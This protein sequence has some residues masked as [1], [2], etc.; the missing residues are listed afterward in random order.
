MPTFLVS[1]PTGRQFEVDGAD[2]NEAISSLQSYLSGEAAP[3]QRTR[4]T[5]EMI[6]AYQQSLGAPALNQSSISDEDLKSKFAEYE[7]KPGF[8]ESLGS[9]AERSFSQAGVLKDQLLS[10]GAKG[11]GYDDY[12]KQKLDEAAAKQ[13]EIQQTNPAQ[14]ESYKDVNWSNLPAY[15]G[16]SIGEQAFN[17][18][19]MLGFGGVGGAIGKR[20]AT[21]AA[22]KAVAEMAA[23]RAAAGA[24]EAAVPAVERLVAREAAKGA[25][26]GGN[27]GMYLG[28]FGL[29]AGDIY[30]GIYD[31]TGEMAPGA[32]VIGASI[33]GFL[34]SIVPARFVKA[35]RET[36]TLRAEV[37]ARIAA[38]KGVAE[39]LL[40]AVK[41]GAM[42][43]LKGGALEPITEVGQEIVNKLAEDIVGESQEKWGSEDFD[44]FIN[45][46]AKSIAPG[47]LFGF[48]EGVGKQSNRRAIA[49]RLEQQ[50][51][52]RQF[53]ADQLASEE[54]RKQQLYEG[55]PELEQQV[56]MLT[57]ALNLP[58]N[59]ARAGELNFNLR[60]T[61]QQLNDLSQ[62]LTILEMPRNQRAQFYAQQQQ[63]EEIAPE[64][65]EAPPTA[66]APVTARSV[67]EPL[68]V[69][70][71]DIKGLNVNPN[72][73]LRGNAAQRVADF[74]DQWR[75][76]PNLSLEQA[77]AADA[78]LAELPELQSDA[79]SVG[80]REDRE[81]H[82]AAAP[83]LVPKK[84]ENWYKA[85]QQYGLTPESPDAWQ[86]LSDARYA[87]RS[88]SVRAAL[89]EKLKADF[90]EQEQGE[91]DRVAALTEQQR[92]AEEQTRAEA[93][94]KK[95]QDATYRKQVKDTIAN[96]LAIAK[97]QQRKLEAARKQAAQEGKLKA[98]Q[99]AQAGTL[100]SELDRHL[101][102]DLPALT[103]AQLDA[104]DSTAAAVALR[105]M[106]D[107]IAKKQEA[108]NNLAPVG[109]RP[110]PRPAT[111]APPNITAMQTV[112]DVLRHAGFPGAAKPNGMQLNA[113]LRGATAEKLANF[114][115]RI[116]PES[117]KDVA[118]G[119]RIDALKE[120]PAFALEEIE[121]TKAEDHQAHI[122]SAAELKRSPEAFKAWQTQLRGNYKLGTDA[123]K[124]Q[125]V[126]RDLRTAQG[127]A[128]DHTKNQ[129]E[130]YIYSSPPLKKI[131]AEEQQ[132]AGPL[133]EVRESRAESSPEIR[134]SRAKNNTPY[135]QDLSGNPLPPTAPGRA[136]T[137]VGAGGRGRTVRLNTV[138]NVPGTYARKTKV[139]VETTKE[140]SVDKV[141]NAPKAAI[142]FASLAKNTRERFQALITDKNYKPLAIV[143]TTHGDIDS[144]SV[145]PSV[146]AMEAFRIKGAAYIWLGHNHPS[147]ES[148]LSTADEQ[149]SNFFV[150]LFRDSGIEVK[151]ILAIAG[152]NTVDN[153]A[154][155][156]FIDGNT[157]S[158]TT[159]VLTSKLKVP[160]VERTFLD[161]GVLGA[162]IT[163]PTSALKEASSLS[164][165][166]TGLLLLDT[167]HNPVGFLPFDL[168]TTNKLRREGG[169]DVIMRA[170]S[171]SNANAV[172]VVDK[173]S[174]LNSPN[175]SN[176][177]TMLKK[178]RLNLLDVVDIGNNPYTWSNRGT[179]PQGENVTFESRQTE[180]SSAK[181]TPE[182][183]RKVIE[184]RMGASAANV[185]IARTP[186]EAGVDKTKGI[187]PL[188]KG[189][190][191]NGKAYLF[192][193]NMRVGKEFGVFLHEVG[194]HLGMKKLVGEGNYNFLVSQVQ[195]WAD[196]ND[197]S[198]ESKIARAAMERIPQ[199]TKKESELL[200]YFI[201]EAVDNYGVNPSEIRDTATPLGVFFRK[202]M[203]GIK[204]IL[205]KLG[206]SPKDLTSQDIIDLAYGAAQL[207]IAGRQI[208]PAERRS[209]A[210]EVSPKF[211]KW[212]STSPTAN[213][214]EN[215]P[216]TPI[217]QIFK[218]DN[219][220]NYEGGPAVFQGLH[221]TTHNNILS[222][223]PTKGSKAGFLGHGPY[224]TTSTD[225]AN[226]NY[227]GFG[228]DLRR[229]IDN[230]THDIYDG[231]NEDEYVRDEVLGEYFDENPAIWNDVAVAQLGVDPNS[232][233]EDL[234]DQDK[235]DLLDQYG[236]AAARKM[237][238]KTVAGK[239]LGLN[240]PVWVKFH[241]PFDM[242]YSAKDYP[243]NRIEI[244]YD[245]DE[246]GDV[247]D[248]SERG[249]GVKL[250]NA[251]REAADYYQVDVTDAVVDIFNGTNPFELYKTLKDKQYIDG[252]TGDY[253]SP[254]QFLQEVLKD[255]GYDGIIMSAHDFFRRMGGVNGQTLHLKPL[256]GN[257]IKSQFNEGNYGLDTDQI[258]KSLSSD[259]NI[260]PLGFYSALEYNLSRLPTKSA[261]AAGWKDAIKG[262]LNKGLVKAEEVE[263][264]GIND[265]LDLTEGK[266][267]REQVQDYLAQGGVQV[268]ETVLGKKNDK[269]LTWGEWSEPDENGH[270]EMK[271]SSGSKIIY[272]PKNSNSGP[273]TPLR[274][275]YVLIDSNGRHQGT[276]NDLEHAKQIT[277]AFESNAIKNPTKY[278][279]YIIPGG[280]NYREVLLK[281]PEI[282]PQKTWEWFDQ[283]S[284]T[285]ER[286][287]DTQ[288][289]A[290]DARPNISAVVNQVEVSSRN[291]NYRH[292]HWPS[293]SNILAHI[294]LND[295]V[296]ADGKRVL[297]IEEVQSDWGQ[298]GK[299]KGFDKGPEINMDL[300][301][302]LG[303][304]REASGI[305]SAPF[306]TKTEGW[307]NLALKRIM[308]MAAEE[309]YD[310]VAFVNGKQSANRYDLANHV[311][312]IEYEPSD[313]GFNIN[314][315]KDEANIKSGD[316]TKSELE[317]M[318][319]HEIVQKMEKGEGKPLF[320]P[321]I[322][323]DLANV[324]VLSDEGLTV[325][326]QGMK[327]F[328]DQIIPSA[329]KK[330]LSK[331]DGG[332]P[333]TVTM[334]RGLPS[335]IAGSQNSDYKDFSRWI[336][337]KHPLEDFSSE[338][339]S[340]IWRHGYNNNLF[341][342][343]WFNDNRVMNQLGFDITPEMVSKIE[344]GLPQ[345]SRAPEVRESRAP[346]V[347]VNPRA[348][349]PSVIGNGTAQGR[350]QLADYAYGRMDTVMRNTP[351][352]GKATMGKALGEL[353]NMPTSARK[354]V[355]YAAQLPQL[356][357]MIDKTSPSAA[358]RIRDLGEVLAARKT[359]ADKRKTFI[360]KI[361][362]D[363]KAAV[364]KYT[365]AQLAKF[366]EVTHNLSR[367]QIDP[368]DTANKTHPLSRQ[369][370]ALPKPLQDIFS[371]VVAAYRQFGDEYLDHMEKIAGPAFSPAMKMQYKMRMKRIMP[372]LP[373]FREGDFWVA[374]TDRTGEA[375]VRACDTDLERSQVMRAAQAAGATD[376]QPF[377]QLADINPNNVK[378]TREF[379]QIFNL[380]KEK[381]V[382]EAVQAKV[383]QT[384]LQMFPAKSIMQQF[385][386]RKGT[387][388]YREDILRNFAIVG[389]RMADNLTQFEFTK[390]IDNVYSDLGKE[391]LKSERS[392]DDVAVDMLN[393][394]KQRENFLRYPV[395][396]KY[397]NLA[398]SAS[399]N[400]FLLGNISSSVMNS[401]SLVMSTLPVL[402][403]EYG[404]GRTAAAMSRA[405]SMYAKGG[406]DDNTSLTIFGRRLSDKT[407]MGDSARG[408]ALEKS[409]PDLKKL[410][411]TAISRQAIHRS[412]GLELHDMRKM[413]LS[414]YTGSW[415]KIKTLLSWLFQNS[416]RMNREITLLAAY[417]L[418][419]DELAKRGIRG[420]AATN[421]A[422]DKAIKA[423]T[424]T[425]GVATPELGSRALQGN[426]GK[427][428][429]TFKKYPMTQ[430]YMVGTLFN[431]AIRGAS[432]KEKQIAQKQ[433][434]G[435]MGMGW[436]FAG[437][438][439]LPLVGGISFLAE[440]II[441]D[442][443]EPFDID[444][445]ALESM[446]NLGWN[447]LVSDMTG[448]RI[449]DRAAIGSFFR[450][451]KKRL[452]ELGWQWYLAEQTIGAPASL[453]KNWIDA[454]ELFQQ[455]YTLKAAER[456]LPLF[457]GNAIKAVDQG[458]NGIVTK[459][460][461]RIADDPSTKDLIMQGIGFRKE[462]TA[463]AQ[464]VN[465]IEN[466]ITT[467]VN[468][469]RTQVLNN[470]WRF[471]NDPERLAEAREAR[472]DFNRSRYGQLPKNRITAE[473]IEKSK[474]QHKVVDRAAA[475]HAGMAPDQRYKAAFRELEESVDR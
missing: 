12:A 203:A 166:D 412:V 67:L 319:G 417:Q 464:D 269:P 18:L 239:S 450:E 323:P 448:L 473:T 320:D 369:F 180:G 186:K 248:G 252:D 281:L 20:V 146:V 444:Q 84:M 235:E 25:G 88:P 461:V 273:G 128:Q 192:T 24:A 10:L 249:D 447:G 112:S 377:K 240:M 264:S 207:E 118:Q 232:T 238:A 130:K 237:A 11:L 415:M 183:V 437:V 102:S 282:E 335:T 79:I 126:Y 242:R 31:E 101:N 315:I 354:F 339:I 90:P 27:I 159:G 171:I 221:G 61:Q 375:V 380:M 397:A 266:I 256:Y 216:N 274:D 204:N 120:H 334:E 32:S 93:V 149:L 357:D 402:G 233:Y 227:A 152:G 429:G 124:D 411:D 190:I 246:E 331:V 92:M 362:L 332:K 336:K 127:I 54:E 344:G 156:Y 285:S 40:P 195:K 194:D 427:V 363:G 431:D 3:Q 312:S 168:T 241:N 167:R 258:L 383:Y 259:K 460:G 214:N 367:E 408:K 185:T 348:P 350:Q 96:F 307:V 95:A 220:Q 423:I 177:A 379:A 422:I 293:H 60:E 57:E 21:S 150:E 387:L 30:Q 467:A 131:A 181:P 209:I 134:E 421:Q 272:R 381:G 364:E 69:S 169:L 46:A 16:E 51:Q 14:F 222:F 265:W 388:G 43:A 107:T 305:P 288:Q 455:G 225:D 48:G 409:R 328:Y 304:E 410:Y 29:N 287:F 64:E 170:M 361:L 251:L 99:D 163:G 28:S 443:D 244:E 49:D 172:V 317:A 345:F 108:L 81:A 136:G 303:I 267:T 231:M 226:A 399:Y 406:R 341:V 247:I 456:A 208:S 98:E 65:E 17:A 463:R 301:R 366:E 314:I 472:D 329:L 42:G 465:T 33:N 453:V 44:R 280:E 76:N 373:L 100:I 318:I 121:R 198:L 75:V 263:W 310:R 162:P 74:I 165:G 275:D 342:Q 458:I 260:S 261:T 284:Q 372:Y 39:G 299:K 276:V 135:T 55:I 161:F 109:T 91:T 452:Q 41:A 425:Q 148:R 322:E 270:K 418:E 139:V 426:I 349:S 119:E 474:K 311:D 144:T 66:P 4:L 62:E 434:L 47:M 436:A 182:Q 343:E 253:V 289:A 211:N 255:V 291:L 63:E 68:G 469:R 132:S 405:L 309:G 8:F 72:A 141:Y 250:V 215:V 129:I 59:R 268:E 245:L 200:A 106:R 459:D 308:I 346:G 358:A 199:G 292:G 164:N 445:W 390:D 316:F 174:T 440:M 206:L 337:K 184:D 392:G 286:G 52:A 143:G 147:G 277:S 189:A 125:A 85:A 396:S 5:P 178:Y 300:A 56:Q 26:V 22:E 401:T 115:Q 228:P 137:G 7:H 321:E 327:T 224:I 179:N 441:G 58:E 347:V 219:P 313:K 15:A 110:T 442:D 368:W 114:L 87:A 34:D 414:E 37:A 359:R 278:N 173:N 326:G 154:W 97:E 432:A 197:G 187:H 384:L 160:I 352:W 254:G 407:F 413:A 338:D 356:A 374:Y 202:I 89:T 351:Q 430:L 80:Q 234:H 196:K 193:D 77:Q 297:F 201:E 279:M 94:F 158:G 400:Q 428:I 394:L 333:R 117:V 462:S 355:Y 395:N 229:H 370:Y 35:L 378:P 13:E 212:L 188:T 122:E 439:G 45:S 153:R 365:P 325:G 424:F 210:A 243:I 420:D 470:L 271:A 53:D 294:R 403:G 340:Q 175:A 105:Q 2:E 382:D 404:Y 435:I 133:A 290:Y 1:T 236:A 218:I 398:A 306:V 151:G 142:A 451:D 457:M 9:G 468:A 433:L 360:E 466:Q 113:P 83:D 295:R 38:G 213:G 140:L 6:D 23:Q 157:Y 257:Q 475:A 103:Q 262:L 19:T 155:S 50:Q 416:E 71:E 371:S 283:E 82:L 393:E 191:I 78:A 205:N 438:K 145:Y 353:S 138:D 223:S 298:E 104:P 324:R 73:P 454:S 296:D 419:V 36:P 217:T 70:A 389:S 471:R 385:R 391:L 386:P 230:A 446:G 86:Q 449:S 302:E 111:I 116:K 123:E 376:I 330:L 176:L